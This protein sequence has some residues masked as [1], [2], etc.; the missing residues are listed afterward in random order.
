MDTSV[1]GHD[2]FITSNHRKI[3]L[4]ADWFDAKA[5]PMGVGSYQEFVLRVIVP[6]VSDKS[7]HE[8]EIYPI[9]TGPAIIPRV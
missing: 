9:G 8:K 6:Q 1:P 4:S 7:A 5:W 2:I 3:N